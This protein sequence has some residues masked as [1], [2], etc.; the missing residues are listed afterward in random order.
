MVIQIRVAYMQIILNIQ[1]HTPNKAQ[2]LPPMVKLSLCNRHF[3]PN[4]SLKLKFILNPIL[5]NLF[6]NTLLN[7]PFNTYSSLN[8][9]RVM[10]DPENT[11]TSTTTS[12]K[13]KLKTSKNY[14]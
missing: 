12:I 2:L 14:I 4:H 9:I 11:I 6:N 3:T 5:P 1:F 8:S 13:I 10:Y 7:S